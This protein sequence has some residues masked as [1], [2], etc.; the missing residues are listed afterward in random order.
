MDLKTL[1]QTYFLLTKIHQELSLLAH[2]QK[3]TRLLKILQMK[4]LHKHFKIL[5]VWTPKAV[6]CAKMFLLP[7]LRWNQAATES[8]AAEKL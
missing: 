1:M 7:S 4:K 6:Q 3:Q 8:L 2:H 5:F